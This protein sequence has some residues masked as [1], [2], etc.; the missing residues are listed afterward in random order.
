M[1]VLKKKYSGEICGLLYQKLLQSL[2]RQL[3]H[4]SLHLM[5]LLFGG[6]GLAAVED[7]NA[8]FENR[9]VARYIMGC[10]QS[11]LMDIS[12]LLLFEYFNYL[13]REGG[14]SIVC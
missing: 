3:L 7:M 9:V 2:N 10:F 12:L 6:R 1:V 13:G 14:R 8:C 5:T 11:S 4:P